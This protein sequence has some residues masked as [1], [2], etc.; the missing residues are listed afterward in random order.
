MTDAVAAM[1]SP[2][3]LRDSQH[4]SGQHAFTL[5]AAATTNRLTQGTLDRSRLPQMFGLFS[6]KSQTDIFVM[7]LFVVILQHSTLILFRYA[8]HCAVE[9]AKGWRPS[10]A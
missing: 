8:A 7:I 1:T 10:T 3:N 6:P 4:R 9:C 5:R 2:N